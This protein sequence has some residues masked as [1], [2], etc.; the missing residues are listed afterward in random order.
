LPFRV[1]IRERPSKVALQSSG[2]SCKRLLTRQRRSH[3]IPVERLY[4]EYKAGGHLKLSHYNDLGRVKGSIEAAV[5][6]AFKA[7]DADPTIPKDPVA[8]LALLRRGLVPW[9]AGI[10]PDT[11]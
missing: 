4:E 3:W 1:L 10:D 8:R 11:G 7:A 9:L 6:R 5:E 2:C